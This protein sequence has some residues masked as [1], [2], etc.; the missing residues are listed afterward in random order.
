MSAARATRMRHE[1]NMNETCATGERQEPSNASAK[2][3]Q[4][5]CYPNN[6]SATRAKNFDFDKDTRENI[7]SH[8]YISYM[9]N[10]RLQGEEQFHSKN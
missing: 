9:A 7:L 3:V 2:R 6:T 5:E 1:C 10:G 8:P 4:H